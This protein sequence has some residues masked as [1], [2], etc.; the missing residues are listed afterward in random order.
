MN[1]EQPGEPSQ[2]QRQID[3]LRERVARNRADLDALESRADAAHHRADA[4][5]ARADKSEARADDSE[6]RADAAEGRAESREARDDAYRARVA[7]LE[8]RL[9]VNEEVLAELQSAGL[10]KDDQVVHLQEALRS[11]RLIG[12]AIGIIMATRK[13][14]QV[15]AFAMLSRGSQ[16][17]NRKVLVL[18][19]EVV[20]TGDV[21]GLPDPLPPG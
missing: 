11:S 13:V 4:S 17:T 15:E 14:S 20:S 18:A 8:A 19:D 7:A 3:D 21:S 9:D 12:A 2:L 5:E 6:A 1:E 16:N 10:V